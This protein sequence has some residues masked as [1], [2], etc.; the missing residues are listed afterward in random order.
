MEA[1]LNARYEDGE[2]ERERKKRIQYEAHLSLSLPRPVVGELES[3]KSDGGRGHPLH[4]GGRRVRVDV[5]RLLPQWLPRTRHHPPRAVDK[6]AP[7][8]AG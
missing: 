4:S 2:R 5:G 8:V 3:V 6:Q 1:C 7:R